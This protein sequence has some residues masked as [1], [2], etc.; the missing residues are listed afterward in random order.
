MSAFVYRYFGSLYHQPLLMVVLAAACSA[1]A[2]LFT[3]AFA[4]RVWGEK[5]ATITAWALFL[6]P[7][8]VL[9]GSSQMRE[10]F[11]IPL[12][13]AAF[14][15][16]VRYRDDRSKSGLVWMLVALLITTYFLDP[17]WDFIAGRSDA[18]CSGA[19]QAAFIQYLAQPLV[20]DQPGVAGDCRDGGA[21]AGA[22][23]SHAAQAHQ[24]D[25]DAELVAA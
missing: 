1:L 13:A 19:A 25:C 17:I 15:G 14:Y 5:V 7:E 9:L 3:W 6:Y 24:S 8:A 20:L 21:V 22:Q 11:T 4:R 2:V 10:A 12:V 16:L 18:G 23:R